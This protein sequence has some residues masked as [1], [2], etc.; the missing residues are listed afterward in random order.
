MLAIALIITPSQEISA[1]PPRKIE[2]TL[3]MTK[4]IM[5]CTGDGFL[6]MRL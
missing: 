3:A 2:I 1:K 4:R 5:I 6:L